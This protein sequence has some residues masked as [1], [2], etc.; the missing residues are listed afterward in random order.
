MSPAV[1]VRAARLGTADRL[2][3]VWI[4]AAMGLGLLLSRFVP[5]VGD[6]LQAL[7]VGSVSLPI[8]VRIAIPVLVYFAVIFTAG[9]VTGKLV[10]LP[11]ERTTTLAFTAA[12]INFELAIAVTIETFGATFGQG[13]PRIGGPLIEVPARVALVYVAFSLRP[14]VFPDLS[15]GPPG[16]SRPPP[17]SVPDRV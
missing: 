5:I 15:S 14:R 2:L 4:L 3:P 1:P 10:G 13:L 9:F 11:Y 17:L 16:A 8:I 7:Q 12:G 6:A